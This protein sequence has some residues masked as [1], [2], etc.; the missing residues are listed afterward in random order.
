MWK[1][2]LLI[3]FTITSTITLVYAY[4]NLEMKAVSSIYNIGGN[5]Y[6][7]INKNPSNLVVSKSGMRKGDKLTLGDNMVPF[8]LLYKLDGYTQYTVTG[9]R[10]NFT[11]PES[12]PISS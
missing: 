11:F 5:V 2:I 8:Q 3:L 12:A 10:K 6:G 9:T 4:L 7:R 1:K